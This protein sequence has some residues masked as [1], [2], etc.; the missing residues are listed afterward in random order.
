MGATLGGHGREPT[1]RRV[2]EDVHTRAV[3]AHDAACLRPWL[4]RRAR[5]PPRASTPPRRDRG[6]AGRRARAA[7]RA[8]RAAHGGGM[9]RA[10]LR[11]QAPVFTAG[12]WSLCGSG[13]RPVTRHP[14]PRSPR[15]SASDR[16][17]R[18]SRRGHAGVSV[19]RHPRCATCGYSD[20][21]QRKAGTAVTHDPR[22]PRATVMRS[23]RAR[24]HRP[25]RPLR[26]ARAAR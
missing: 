26:R 7:A 16:A 11:P 4:P 3:G 23:R 17:R 20:G 2:P 12:S 19:T 13:V 24:A 1:L 10:T 9:S 21:F 14:R 18:G 25:R 15:N 5:S 8:S 22:R 6:G